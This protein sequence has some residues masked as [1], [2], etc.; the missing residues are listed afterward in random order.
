ME[1]AQPVALLITRVIV[2]IIFIAHGWEKFTSIDAT[3]AFF[4]SAHVPLPGVSTLAAA[5]LELVGGVALVL[6]LLLPVFGTLL[7]LDML[8]AIFFVHASKGFWVS[9]GGYEF[10]LALAAAIIAIAYS[11]GG[12][13]AVDCLWR[14]GREAQR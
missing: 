7:V 14:R 3:T 12:A 10:V 9:Q 6:G 8:L 5:A 2:G 11:G 1:K 13:L 4:K